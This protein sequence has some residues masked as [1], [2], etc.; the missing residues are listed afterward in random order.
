MCI[1]WRYVLPPA[2]PDDEEPAETVRKQLADSA[3]AKEQLV[4][5]EKAHEKA[6]EEAKA[7]AKQVTEEANADTKRL[8]EQLR[9]QADA[10]VERIEVHRAQQVRL[11]RAQLI[12]RLRQDLGG[13]SVRRAGGL[14]DQYISDADAQSATV[15]RFID[16]LT[17]WHRPKRCRRPATARLRAA[18]RESLATLVEKFDQV[19]ADLGPDQLSS[20]ASDLAWVTDLL[21]HESVLT[22]HLADPADDPTPSSAWWRRCSK[23]RSAIRR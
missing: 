4:K 13:G 17:R 22:R 19:T 11:L 2:A 7:Q 18:S 21:A 5:A 3:E 20:V 12:R 23:A 8:V 1:V 6:V 16:K 15:D 14:V 10:E 9:A